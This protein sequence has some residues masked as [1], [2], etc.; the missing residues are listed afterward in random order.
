MLMNLEPNNLVTGGPIGGTD[1]QG[2]EMIN[3]LMSRV[4]EMVSRQQDVTHKDLIIFM[5]QVG[6]QDTGNS[7]KLK[8]FKDEDF[9]RIIEA[10]IFD[11]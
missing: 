7:D 10:M 9:T 1:P 5:K 8:S 4:F 2:I 11:Q 3:G 6:L